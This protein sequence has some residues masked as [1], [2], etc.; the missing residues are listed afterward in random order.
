MLA[1]AVITELKT[2]MIIPSSSSIWGSLCFDLGP[3][4]GMP[5]AGRRVC[6]MMWISSATTFADD[7][8]SIACALLG[9]K[10]QHLT[11]PGKDNRC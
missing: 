3:C 1:S 2:V 9:V 7:C 6:T 11:V 10:Q 8:H 4:A 5:C